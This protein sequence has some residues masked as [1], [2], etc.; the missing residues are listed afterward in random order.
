MDVFFAGDFPRGGAFWP[1]GF[2]RLGC[3][4]SVFWSSFLLG[5]SGGSTE[6]F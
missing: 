3:G 5:S 4:S 6:G 1:V 2:F